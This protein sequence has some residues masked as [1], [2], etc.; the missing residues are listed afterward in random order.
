VKFG[1]NTFIWGSSFG[2][3]D[4]H[5]L[6]AVKQAGFD[7]IEMP[8]LDPASFNARAV[9]KELDRVGLERTTCSAVPRG[10]SLASSDA[11][12]RRSA[13]EFFEACIRSAGEAGATLLSG[14]FYT[15]VGAMTGHRRTVDEWKWTVDSWQK[16]V[17]AVHAAGIEVC[18]EPL[19]RFETYFLNVTADAVRLCDE[20]AD[21]AI[22]IL[23]D[24]FHANI[25]EKTIG[26]AVR[27]AAPHL[28]HV[29]ISEN[30][31]GTP[32]SGHVAWAELFA[33]LQEVGYDRWLTIE[34]FGFAQGPMAAAAAIWRDLAITPDAIAFDGLAFLQANVR[35][36][37]R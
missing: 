4:F 20:I 29:H 37:Q 23:V 7:G 9:G 26:D 28:K 30:D 34:S 3:D 8:I 5:R 25:E 6:A 13:I 27:T 11:G 16:L 12:V 18:L 10:L 22:G 33:V 32:G 2:P 1:V 14:P 17:P 15:P 21:P 19:N 31:R 36:T 24:S 35:R